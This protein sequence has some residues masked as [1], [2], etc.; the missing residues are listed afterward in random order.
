[1]NNGATDFGRPGETLSLS[2]QRGEGPGEG[3]EFDCESVLTSAFPGC[4]LRLPISVRI[5]ARPLYFSPL[6]LPPLRGEGTATR[7][8]GDSARKP[9][10]QQAN[11]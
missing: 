9:V 7:T 6:T 10:I 1:M 4:A 8:F 5:I 3:W 11:Q 2:P